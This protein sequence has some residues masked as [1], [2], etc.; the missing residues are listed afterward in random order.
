MFKDGSF[1][2]PSSTKRMECPHVLD[3][4][5]CISGFHVIGRKTVSQRH[6]PT[7]HSVGRRLGFTT[8]HLKQTISSH[9]QKPIA[10]VGYTSEVYP[11]GEIDWCGWLDI[12][13]SWW[14]VVG[15]RGGGVRPTS[16]RRS[17]SLLPSASAL[18]G[19]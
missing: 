1:L 5:G 19:G 6:P 7:T 2:R 14:L 11:I 18:V 3:S 9:L 10:P 13:R 17:S 4:A 15:L 12:V 8:S 16:A